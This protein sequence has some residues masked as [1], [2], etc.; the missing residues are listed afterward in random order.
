MAC[1][2]THLRSIVY[3]AQVSTNGT[4]PRSFDYSQYDSQGICH[5]QLEDSEGDDYANTPTFEITSN[6]AVESKTWGP[7]ASNSGNGAAPA[8][9]AI[10]AS[11]STPST[12]SSLSSIVSAGSP[13]ATPILAN[14]TSSSPTST[15]PAAS[16][17]P[18]PQ[19]LSPGAKADISI[20]SSFCA[21]ALTIAVLLS[22]DLA[23]TR[24]RT[25]HGQQDL[26]NLKPEYQSPAAVELGDEGEALHEISGEERLRELHGVPRAELA[27]VP[28][29]ERLET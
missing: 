29:A 5:A 28:L 6:D 24:R 13:S 17:S 25:L 27:W 14:P 20:G 18:P 3:H 23:Q 21:L 16:P 10:S 22:R 12:T 8:T 19:S 26:N 4:N 9:T 7:S 11:N 2:D 15:D 1:A